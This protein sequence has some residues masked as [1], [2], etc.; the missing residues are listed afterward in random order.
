MIT[1]AIDI[2]VRGTEVSILGHPIK[3]ETTS[4]TEEILYQELYGI[5]PSGDWNLCQY[6]SQPGQAAPYSYRGQRY[7][8]VENKARNRENNP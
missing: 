4:E 1:L 3:N 5:C 2:E 8:R 6:D 7:E